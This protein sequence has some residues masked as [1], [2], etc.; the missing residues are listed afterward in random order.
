MIRGIHITSSKIV[1]SENSTE[2]IKGFFLK[3]GQVVTARVVELLSGNRA[4]FMINGRQV[5]VKTAL[6]FTVGEQVPLQ[7][8]QKDARF[9]LELLPSNS[10]KA[11]MPSGHINRVFIKNMIWPE[12]SKDNAKTLYRFLE[13]ISLKSGKPD[14][15]LLARLIEKGGLLFESKTA[16]LFTQTVQNQSLQGLKDPL[17]SLVNQDMKG[18]ALSELLSAEPGSAGKRTMDA[19]I[20]MLETFQQISRQ[21][22]DAGR[23]ILPLPFLSDSVFK[24]GQLLIDTGK[25]DTKTGSPKKEKL[26]RVSFFLE[27]SRLGAL[28]ADF[29]ILNKTLSGRFLLSDPKTCQWV[30]SCIP[31]LEDRLSKVKF[32][33]Q[34]VTCETVSSE[35]LD[36]NCLI[37]SLAKDQ[38]Y[39]VLNIVV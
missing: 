27:M 34:N 16:Q 37:E 5:H 18:L 11:E 28:R 12:I 23:T 22:S 10:Q 17:A 33:L 29:S 7:V 39:S 21:G 9:V 15:A 6:P 32:T 2:N 14:Q 30:E 1:L 19:L 25:P 20:D 3:D 31:E 38:E 8:A 13:T 26:T 24:F 35:K 4:V 36:K